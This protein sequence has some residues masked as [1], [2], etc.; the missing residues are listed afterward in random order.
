VN[1]EWG[2]SGECGGE[3]GMPDQYNLKCRM[4]VY[5][6]CAAMFFRVSGV[7]FF[8]QHRIIDFNHVDTVCRRSLIRGGSDE[9][10]FAQID[11]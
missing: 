2:G 9:N 5:D 3:V 7:D 11:V 1:R 10:T 4:W 8:A 6:Y